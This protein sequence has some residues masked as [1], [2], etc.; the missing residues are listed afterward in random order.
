MTVEEELNY[1]RDCLRSTQDRVMALEAE[2]RVLAACLH[3]AKAMPLGLVE[4]RLH[5]AIQELHGRHPDEFPETVRNL[6]VL[7]DFC[8]GL[9]KNEPNR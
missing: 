7:R 2:V 8:E 6:I 5:Q 9:R 3:E 4:M 1:L